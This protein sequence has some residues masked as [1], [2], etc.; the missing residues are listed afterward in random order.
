MFSK[1]Y[2]AYQYKDLLIR[3]EDPYAR[4]KYE[5]ILAWLAKYKIKNVLNAGCGSG[6]LCLLLARNGYHVTGFDPDR[7]YIN[8]AKKN[9]KH[10]KCHFEVAKIENFKV[11][12]KFDVV[13]A[14][15]VLEHIKNDKK[16]WKLLAQMVKPGGLVVITVPAG[17]Y[18][19]GFHDKKLGHFRRYS[20]KSL[21]EIRPNSLTLLDFRYFGF[22]LIP[23][24]WIVSKLVKKSYPVA[25]SNTNVFLKL[26]LRVE[27]WLRLPVGTSLLFLGKNN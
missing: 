18:L 4:V 6:E 9:D 15:D 14:T 13:V 25:R 20:K 27:K 1:T 22:F 21:M 2:N 5:I 16:A 10:G 23:I 11:R 19:F 26:I 17:Q 12:D 7:D 8:L 24:A 3:N